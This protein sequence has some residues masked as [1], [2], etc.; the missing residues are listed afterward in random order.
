V[1]HHLPASHPLNNFRD[2]ESVGFALYLLG[3]HRRAIAQ[4]SAVDKW[5]NTDGIIDLTS[6]NGE[7]IGKFDIQIKKLPD[8]HNMVFDLDVEYLSY[9][10]SVASE[11]TIALMVDP[12]E[13]KIYWFHVTREWIRESNY[14]K[15]KSTVRIKLNDEHCFDRTNTSYIKQ[16]EQIA[17][18]N[19]RHKN[20]L[21]QLL[22]AE[23]GRTS[24]RI[25][26]LD[27][28][29]SPIL[30]NIKMNVIT[31]QK[32]DDGTF[33]FV[34]A[35]TY[36]FEE[37]VFIHVEV[38]L[39][40]DLKPTITVNMSPM[41]KENAFHN[42]MYFKCLSRLKNGEVIYLADNQ[43]D[44]WGLGKVEITENPDNIEQSIEFSKTVVD[45]EKHINEKLPLS[46]GKTTP[47]EL[48]CVEELIDIT[49]KG[50]L[51]IATTNGILL[52]LPADQIDKNFPTPL[53]FSNPTSRSEHHWEFN[54][55]KKIM[56]SSKPFVILKEETNATYLTT[57]P[58]G[59][60]VI[61]FENFYKGH[62]DEVF[63]RIEKQSSGKLIDGLHESLPPI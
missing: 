20:M 21:Q 9:C 29:Y 46:Q 39:S 15:N 49:E 7:L 51:R 22:D 6:V 40:P 14:A 25:N 57:D 48:A 50:F 32:N 42:L 62:I 23:R 26:L 8:N 53:C 55:G 54:L 16:W 18:E 30:A 34:M 17:K 5:P 44:F 10:D 38:H 60:L 3:K 11:P 36:E 4:A 33:L 13:E 41:S 37:S 35:N 12:I 56:V 43:S 27:S 58:N 52:P 1:Y 45:L 61:I 2:I 59:E 47:H 19:R 24:L 31:Q 28:E 63:E